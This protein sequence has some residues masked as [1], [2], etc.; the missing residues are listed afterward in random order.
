[1]TLASLDISQEIGS[2][3][4]HA[5]GLVVLGHLVYANDPAAARH[6]LETSVA[7]LRQAGDLSNLSFALAH[8]AAILLRYGDFDGAEMALEEGLALAQITGDRLG[9][10]WITN[11]LGAV[12]QQKGQYELAEIRYEAALRL[13]R[14][15]G[16][17][18]GEVSVQNALDEMAQMVKHG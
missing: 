7:M 15:L 2:Q 12:A 13:F 4:I 14:H 8:L 17:R 1:M 16:A 18:S 10:A 9:T 11:E 6:H 3:W 5:L